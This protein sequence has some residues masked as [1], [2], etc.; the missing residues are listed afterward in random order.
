[1]EK[2]K[3]VEMQILNYPKLGEGLLLYLKM[4]L[5][6]IEVD[7]SRQE[8]FLDVCREAIER[9]ITRAYDGEGVLYAQ[10]WSTDTEI[11]F[12]LR[13]LG[14]LYGSQEIRGE[15]DSID[16]LAVLMESEK[17][18]GEVRTKVV[19]LGREGQ[20]VVIKMPIVLDVSFIRSESESEGPKDTN[21]HVKEVLDDLEDITEA[22]ACLHQ[23]YGFSYAY[24]DL[25]KADSFKE[26]VK[27]GAFSSYLAVNDHGEIAGHLGLSESSAL[28]NMPE[29]SS[30]VI[31]RQFRGLHFGDKMFAASVDQARLKGKPAVWVQPTAFHTGTQRICNKLGFT[32]CGFLFEYVNKDIVSEYNVNFRRLDLTMAV[33]LFEDYQFSFYCP[34]EIKTFSK[35][36]FSDLKSP[37]EFKEGNGYQSES[38]IQVDVNPRTLSMK[39]VIESA[40]EDFEDIIFQ[41][42][43]R[44]QQDK[45]EMVEVLLSLEDESAIA[46]YEHLRQKHFIFGGI[47]PGSD[48]GVYCVMQYLCGNVPQFD[49][50]VT[51]DGY[52][53]V[54]YE[55]KK[56][57]EGC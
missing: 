34:E 39:L 36:V 35:K 10:I 8:D 17:Q 19:Q 50:L 30:V 18:D 12:T 46:A 9:R 20:M 57:Y 16:E 24:E 55:L 13:D 32:P 11:E 47:L 21:F 28:P 3:W 5:E 41:N 14:R 31:K 4:I 6:Q 49:K 26:I 44:V 7:E 43:N 40:G 22:I 38:T 29:I 1:M 33:K 23:E 27:S 48:K 37:V 25:Y 2:K 56:I 53:E 15:E 42:M 52:T 45:L 54:L 51:T